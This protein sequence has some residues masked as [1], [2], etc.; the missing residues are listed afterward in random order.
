MAFTSI[1]VGVV[2]GWAA[3]GLLGVHGASGRDATP[4]MAIAALL[5]VVTGFV[6]GVW[7]FRNARACLAG[8][9]G[10]AVAVGIL[11]VYFSGGGALS[12]FFF[13]WFFLVLAVTLVPWALGVFAG[14]WARRVQ[15]SS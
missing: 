1:V 6:Y 8:L 4:L 12:D 3:F 2:V 14:R 7:W 9:A 10:Y 13:D 15:L 5:L 11:V